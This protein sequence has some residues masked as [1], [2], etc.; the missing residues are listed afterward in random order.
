MTEYRA[1]DE[2]PIV[3]K[4]WWKNDL[5]ERKTREDFSVSV[6]EESSNY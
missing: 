2:I 4:D 6:Q 3:R 1:Q 5:E